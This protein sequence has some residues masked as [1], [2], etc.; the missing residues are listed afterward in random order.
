[1][2][3]GEPILTKDIL[4]TEFERFVTQAKNQKYVSSETTIVQHTDFETLERLI[5]SALA[6]GKLKQSIA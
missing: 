4:E 3:N 1:L 2:L 6:F 5:K